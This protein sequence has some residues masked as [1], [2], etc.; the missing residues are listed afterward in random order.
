MLSCPAKAGKRDRAF[1][2]WKG[3]RQRRCSLVAVSST[4]NFACSLLVVICLR[5][6][7]GVT[8]DAPSTTLRVVPLPR[9]RGGGRAHPFSRCGC[10]RGSGTAARISPPNERGGRAPT[11]ALWSAASCGCGSGSTGSRSPLGAP[12][13]RLPCKSMP[14]LSPGRASRETPSEGVTS[15]ANRAY[16][17]A[18]RA[19]VLMPAGTMP[20]PPGSGVTSPARRHR[21]RSVSRPSPVDVPCEER[22]WRR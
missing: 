17:E 9:W 6:Q 10:I 2:R 18:P 15:A 19:P 8:S 20:G 3:P 1:A 16:S 5:R 13:R 4:S 7:R 21:A 14:W 11:G 22:A 12:P